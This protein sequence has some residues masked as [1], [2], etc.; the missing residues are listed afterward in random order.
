MRSITGKKDLFKKIPFFGNKNV[1]TTFLVRHIFS[2]ERVGKLVNAENAA[3]NLRGIIY[4]LEEEYKLGY[5]IS[6]GFSNLNFVGDGDKSIIVTDNDYRD[7]EMYSEF[8]FT[9]W[10]CKNMYFGDFK[11]EAREVDLYNYMRQFVVVYSE[12]VYVNRVDLII[13]QSTYN[14]YYFE[15]KQYSNFCCYSGNKNV[16][17]DNCRMEQMSGTFRGANLGI[18]D[19]WSAGEENITVMNCDFYGNARDEQIGFFSRND[20]KASVKHVNFL[21]N[22]MHSVQLKYVDIIGTRTMC[23]TVAYADSKN[24]EDIRIAGNHFICETD[25]KFMTMGKMKNCRVEDNIIEVKCTNRT[26]SMLFDSS[27]SSAENILIQNNDIFVTSDVGIG[28]GNIT[29][30]NLT[31]KNNRIL[32]DVPLVFGVLG[33]EIHNNEIIGLAQCGTI[34]TDSNMTGNKIYLYSELGSVSTNKK[35]FAIYTGSN[36]KQY[37]F[38]NNICYDY[39]R[40]LKWEGLRGI[41]KIEGSFDSLKIEKNEVY[42]PNS[43]FMTTD[44]TTK[45]IFEDER[46]KYY[47]NKVFRFR[48]GEVGKVEVTNNIFQ[49]T[50]IPESNDVFKYSNNKEIPPEEDPNFDNYEKL[51]IDIKISD[52][53]VISLEKTAPGGN[54]SLLYT[55]KALKPG[56]T[57]IT[58][59]SNDEWKLSRTIFA[60]TM[61]N[62]TVDSKTTEVVAMTKGNQVSFVPFENEAQLV[63]DGLMNGYMIRRTFTNEFSDYKFL[64]ATGAQT[65]TYLDEDVAAGTTYKYTIAPCYEEG[66]NH[67]LGI[68]NGRFE[69]KTLENLEERPVVIEQDKEDGTSDTGKTDNTSNTDKEEFS[70]EK[71]LLGVKIPVGEI[72][73]VKN[74]KYKILSGNKV[75]VVGCKNKNI[76]T[77]TIGSTVKIWESKYN[78]VKIDASALKELKKLKKVVI[79]AKITYIGKGAFAN[80]GKLTSVVL[81]STKV[82]SFGKNA[83]VKINKKAVF[84]VPKKCVKKYK[85][86]LKKK[87]GL[88]KIKVVVR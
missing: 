37:E 10:G 53:S 34:G 67:F 12:N 20:D 71:P 81:K 74:I 32:F 35:Q 21:N 87:T 64:P 83:W 65:Y 76:K 51:N 4:L 11:I 58:F 23:F 24:I 15:D 82:K 31:L 59:T 47:K 54:K 33:P 75:S 17:V 49:N 25:S 80:D 45:D 73:T 13:P 19:I 62:Q 30:G 78:I 2:V 9:C 1:L 39:M 27:N 66:E 69:V 29:V 63:S 52:P 68:N 43:R 79:G 44:I 41:F 26:W 14:S 72:Y 36:A 55:F 61:T 6:V 86:L 85:K 84:Y 8:L 77:I 57:T 88:K 42:F 60:R 18:L 3:N 22:T 7:E 16:T 46:G 48:F 40:C 70:T 56:S 38:K 28:R 50:I 5:G